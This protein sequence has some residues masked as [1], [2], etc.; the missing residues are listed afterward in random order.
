LIQQGGE[1]GQQGPT[2]VVLKP[3]EEGI[4]PDFSEWDF[5]RE[6]NV[7]DQVGTGRRLIRAER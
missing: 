7:S 3:I 1:R 5:E 6:V 2:A 4:F